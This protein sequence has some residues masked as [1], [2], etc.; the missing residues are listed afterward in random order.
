MFQII[1][2]S[3]SVYWSLL[4]DLNQIPK[5]YPYFYGSKTSAN[6]QILL[7]DNSRLV[8]KKYFL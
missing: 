1:N 4:I 8:Q 5:S 7:H 3:A 6:R 2:Q